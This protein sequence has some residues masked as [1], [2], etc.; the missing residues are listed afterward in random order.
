VGD[1]AGRVETS[2]LWAL[3]PDCVDL[4]RLPPEAEEG[5]HFCLGRNAYSS[6]RRVGER[7]VADEVAAL[8]PLAAR[9]LADFDAA[10]R[11]RTFTTFSHVEQVWHD[12]IRPRLGELK[13]MQPEWPGRE[14]CPPDSVWAANR[15]IPDLQA[16]GWG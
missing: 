13:T 3:E 16:K 11:E 4:S 2:L 15:P 14:V 7:M 12:A 1:H 9:L 6:D 5:P 10:P 8:G